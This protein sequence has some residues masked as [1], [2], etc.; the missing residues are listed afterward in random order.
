MRKEGAQVDGVGFINQ[1][2]RCHAKGATQ[3]DQGFE[4]GDKEAHRLSMQ[5]QSKHCSVA[6]RVCDL[7]TPAVPLQGAACCSLSMQGQ[8]KHCR[9]VVVMNQVRAHRLMG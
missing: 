6:A 9:S 2:V 5:G 4:V 7:T 8:S 1:G 3:K